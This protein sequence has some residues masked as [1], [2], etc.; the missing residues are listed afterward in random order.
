MLLT[1]AE[2]DVAARTAEM[3]CDAELASRIAVSAA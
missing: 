3:E 2:R 1:S